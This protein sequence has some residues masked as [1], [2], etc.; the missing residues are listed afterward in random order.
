MGVRKSRIK[1]TSLLDEIK[2]E[3]S[4]IQ[5]YPLIRH[6]VRGEGNV[7]IGFI[8][9][10]WSRM[11]VCMMLGVECMA[12]LSMIIS[13]NGVILMASSGVFEYRK[14][15]KSM[16]YMALDR[17]ADNFDSLADLDWLLMG[18]AIAH[19][20]MGLID[21]CDAFH[22]QFLDWLYDRHKVSCSSSWGKFIE[23]ISK[24]RAAALQT[25]QNWIRVF[26]NEWVDSPDNS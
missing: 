19:E 3:F 5:N 18:H 21:R 16:I 13:L 4:Q 24:D 15:C 12:F 6:L 20:Q 8:I 22:I 17:F 10:W 14:S 9:G 1:F 23:S 7:P 2:S 25:F 11:G 26:L